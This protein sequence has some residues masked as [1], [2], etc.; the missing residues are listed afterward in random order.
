M[1]DYIKDQNPTYIYK[2]LEAI[3]DLPAE[4]ASANIPEA[5]YVSTLHKSAFAD[6]DNRLFP[7]YDEVSTFLSACNIYGT[8]V[9]NTAVVELLEK[10]ASFL[11][12]KDLVEE[13][14]SVF[15]APITKQASN[16]EEY[17]LVI[18][19]DGIQTG[20]LP[21]NDILDIDLSCRQWQA[22]RNFAT[23][24]SDLLKQAAV[25]IVNAADRLN[26][27]DSVPYII[28]EAAE[29]RFPD[30]SRVDRELEF[31]INSVEDTD[32]KELYI[33]MASVG[34]LDVAKEWIET[35]DLLDFSLLTPDVRKN[36]LFK[37]ASEI[38]FSGTPVKEIEKVANSHVSV[39]I[40]GN[41]LLLPFDA[42]KTISDEDIYK[43]YPKSSADIIKEAKYSENTAKATFLIS[44]LVEQDKLDFL[45]D[46]QERA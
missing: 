21:V 13:V 27:S 8:G 28:K 3:K 2:A 4:L 32:S 31:R 22:S 18:E 35:M 1:S 7:C 20:Y 29:D 34:V 17:A 39:D 10:R 5:S 30:F 44:Q 38:I 6:G 46:L 15:E 43:F 45:S 41:T 40:N 23:L 9:K 33:K 42:L 36:P 19:E 14:K 37:T 16:V 12:L 24:P 26:V 11:G 25:V